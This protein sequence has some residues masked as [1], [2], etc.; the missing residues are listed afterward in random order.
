MQIY[1]KPK[2]KEQI[3]CQLLK[4]STNIGE[5]TVSKLERENKAH[6]QRFEIDLR[7]F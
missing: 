3:E 7:S 2:I 6:H 1:L 4:A 5:M